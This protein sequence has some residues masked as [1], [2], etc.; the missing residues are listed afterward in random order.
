MD[1]GLDVNMGGNATASIEKE[2]GFGYVGNDP[3][4]GQIASLM[5]HG[6]LFGG[7]GGTLSG[8][9]GMQ[10]WQFTQNASF[11]N[12]QFVLA[13]SFAYTG[14]VESSL[15]LFYR[16]WKGGGE[17]ATSAFNFAVSKELVVQ[18]DKGVKV[19][20]GPEIT[21]GY[22]AD[23]FGPGYD[24]RYLLLGVS[25]TLTVG[26][27]EFSASVVEPIA[28]VQNAATPIFGVSMSLNSPIRR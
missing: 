17:I 8:A 22:S 21:G 25:E 20:I 5:L 18:D 10:G 16:L 26:E 14:P 3:W 23:M 6:D 2:I 12:G 7:K 4:G 9:I 15:N 19:V 24:P 11:D 1:I 28:F 13:G 27:L